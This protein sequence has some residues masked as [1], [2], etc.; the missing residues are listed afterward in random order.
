MPVRTTTE[1]RLALVLA[2]VPWLHERGGGSVAEVAEHFG[3]PEREVFRVLND[4]QCCEV[5]PYGGATIGIAVFDDG[6]IL[7]EPTVAFERPLRFSA[8]EAFGLLVTARTALARPGRGPSGEDTA[9]LGR[10][11]AKLEAQLGSVG[12]VEVDL[13]RPE[14]LDALRAAVDAHERLRLRYYAASRDEV[15]ERLVDP[16][17][18]FS[19]DGHWYLAAH[20]HRAGGSRT[21][22]VDRVEG[23]EETGQHFDPP[24]DRP[25]APATVAPVAGTTPV[26]LRLPAGSDWVTESYA[27]DDV[28]RLDDGGLEITVASSGEVWLEQLLLRV[29][30][31]GR[32][33]S[34]PEL[35]DA[36]VA[37]A[38]RVLARY[39]VAR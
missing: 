32:V 14:E 18:L 17:R 28:V 7:V 21:F 29:G 5:P 8:D 1:D 9:P 31:G 37:A 6:Q 16:H 33:L 19:S 24:A 39:G 23:L 35:R 15:S 11:L 2:V 38:R 25:E 3:L 13:D 30:A 12:D 4:V 22:R 27:A 34:P 36:G 10:A 26:R 20:C